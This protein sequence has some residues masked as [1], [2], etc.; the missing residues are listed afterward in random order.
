[1]AQSDAVSDARLAHARA[2][3]DLRAAELAQTRAETRAAQ[4]GQAAE[5]AQNRIDAAARAAA[6]AAAGAGVQALVTPADL[7]LWVAAQGVARAAEQKLKRCAEAHRATLDKAAALAAELAPLI[8]LHDPEFATLIDAAR[9]RAAQE[10]G[11]PRR[12]PRRAG[13]RI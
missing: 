13:R 11:L 6:E 4:A 10:R 7:A 5:D 2:L 3:A 12:W 8:D 9:R 1:M